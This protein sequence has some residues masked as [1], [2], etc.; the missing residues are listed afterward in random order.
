MLRIIDWVFHKR[1]KEA[2]A[3]KRDAPRTRTTSQKLGGERERLRRRRQIAEGRLTVANGLVLAREQYLYYAP[4][5]GPMEDWSHKLKDGTN[6][7]LV[8]N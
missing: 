3:I 4:P 2:V 7:P 1:A 5:D 6:S 8:G